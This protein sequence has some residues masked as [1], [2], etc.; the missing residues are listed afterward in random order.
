[1]SFGGQVIVPFPFTSVIQ[2]REVKKSS[3]DLESRH[4]YSFSFI[5]ILMATAM[6]KSAPKDEI[7]ISPPRSPQPAV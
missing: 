5:L 2:G 4:D 7:V 1:M 3:G 6:R